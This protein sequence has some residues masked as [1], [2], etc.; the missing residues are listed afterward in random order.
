[1]YECINV[2][3]TSNIVE[4]NRYVSNTEDNVIFSFILDN[5]IIKHINKYHK[6]NDELINIQSLSFNI[7]NTILEGKIYYKC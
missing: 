7:Y 2:K 4:I 5:N 6:N 3:S 1:M